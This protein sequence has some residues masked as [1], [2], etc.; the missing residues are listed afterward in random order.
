MMTHSDDDPIEE[1]VLDAYPVAGLNAAL[2][3]RIWER[4][5]RGRRRRQWLFRVAI[6]TSVVGG[7]LAISIW[8]SER[9]AG[10]RSAGQAR[11]AEGSVNPG[12]KK[13][14]TLAE[15]TVAVVDRSADIVWQTKGTQV[16]VTQRRGRVF[17]RVQPGTDFR[18]ETPIGSV[19]ALGTCF[20]V[21]VTDMSKQAKNIAT[22]AV[23]AA[24]ASGVWIT[25]YEGR[26]RAE[27]EGV[28]QGDAT[29]LEPG[30]TAVME[31]GVSPRITETP[32]GDD[33]ATRARLAEARRRLMLQA[34]EIAGLEQQLSQRSEGDGAAEY[35]EANSKSRFEQEE[36]DT[37]WAS[38]QELD[39]EER[40]D[41]YMGVEDG[42]STTECRDRC[43]HV[44]LAIEDVGEYYDVF[45]DF[46]SDVGIGIGGYRDWSDLQDIHPRR[47]DDGLGH[48]YA[49]SRR[50]GE[51]REGPDRGAERERMLLEARGAIESCRDQLESE[52]M[53]TMYVTID[54]NGAVSDIDTRAEPAGQ[55]ATHCVEQ[56]VLTSARF[57]P[58]PEE[59]WIPVRVS[60]SPGEGQQ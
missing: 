29:V 8:A 58:A 25:V 57:E 2:E 28:S 32:N 43:C 60:L 30:Q 31:A 1:D 21:E 12:A 44:E 6:A 54:T 52:L 35:E 9:L 55:P 45:V 3:D 10:S 15:Q 33:Q 20:E 59:T 5:E 49:C 38:A 23:G 37:V 42:V 40:L 22:A 14:V 7:L 16:L 13:T 27:A 50:S 39:L 17:Y 36:R 47:S 11:V 53:V 26:V 24:I 48:I 34:D 4:F 41:Q 18:V 51:V 19:E 46:K 56:A